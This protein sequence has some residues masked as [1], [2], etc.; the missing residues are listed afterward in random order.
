[1]V[2]TRLGLPQCVAGQLA[3]MALDTPSE[4][5]TILSQAL[6]TSGLN[7]VT[8]EIPNL[9]PERE[10]PQQRGLVMQALETYLWDEIRDAWESGKGEK[11]LRELANTIRMLAAKGYRKVDQFRHPTGGWFVDPSC[12]TP[13]QR[14]GFLTALVGAMG[15]D[16]YHAGEQAAR[17]IPEVE[18]EQSGD[19]AEEEGDDM[20]EVAWLMGE[21]SDVSAQSDQE[22]YKRK[23]LTINIKRKK[24]GPAPSYVG[25]STPT[26][27]SHAGSEEEE[28]EGQR[29]YET[30]IPTGF[31]RG[32]E[33]LTDEQLVKKLVKGKPVLLREGLS[34]NQS[35]DQSPTGQ[36]WF[37]NAVRWHGGLRGGWS[38]DVQLNELSA[39]EGGKCVEVSLDAE[40]IREGMAALQPDPAPVVLWL[41]T[42]EHGGRGV[43]GVDGFVPALLKYW[44]GHDSPPAE[45]RRR[46]LAREMQEAEQQ[47]MKEKHKKLQERGRGEKAWAGQMRLPARAKQ[48]RS[49]GGRVE[50]REDTWLQ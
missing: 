17:G 32:C 38:V 45:V 37:A 4:Y 33:G 46:L 10:L 42:E 2:E 44:K 47:R 8:L 15:G 14:D 40:E 20:E 36:G 39:Y 34:C 25:F 30:E 12:G 43:T 22:K 6:F 9:L 5:P 13:E 11:V 3:L 29:L 50:W 21:M 24:R 23:G 16:R 31:I 28:G 48:Q 49:R 1:M 18:G 7:G 41:N 19:A 35:W 26:V 27:L